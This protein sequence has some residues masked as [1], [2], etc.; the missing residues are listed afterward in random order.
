MLETPSGLRVLV[1]TVPSPV[2][3]IYLWI[4]AGSADERDNE[5][6][7][8]HFVEH[9]LFKGTAR[10]SVGE[11]ALEIE[12]HGGHVNAYTGHDHTVVHATVPASAWAETI[13]VLADM[14][15]E[16]LF[17]DDEFELER[18]VILDEIRGGD[19]DAARALADGVSAALFRVHPYGRPVIGK[20]AELRRLRSA[21]ARAFHARWYR[22]AN[23]L[24]SVAGPVSEEDVLE[25]AGRLFP[26]AVSAIDKPPRPVEPE[27]RRRR[28][29][30][31]FG[32]F[33]EP[34]I[35]LAFRGVPRDHPDAPVLDLLVGIL[36][37]SPGSLLGQRLQL[38]S[39]ATE[40]WC[41][42]EQEPDDGSFLVGFSPI[43]GQTE[44]CL[45]E[46]AR[47]LAEVAGGRHLGFG[48]LHRSRTQL[49]SGRVFVQETVDGRAHSRAWHTMRSGD[50]EGHT[51]AQAKLEA[52]TTRDLRRVAAERIRP[53]S[54]V[55]GG[56][57]PSGELDAAS[58]RQALA[59]PRIAPPKRPP[60]ILRETL[61]CGA[62][63]LI[64]PLEHSGVVALRVCGLGGL[65]AEGPTT[66]GLTS[67]WA[68][69]VG[70]EDLDVAE[71]AAFLDARGGAL[72]GVAGM[73]SFGLRT[74][75][76]AERFD[77]AARV[78]CGLLR[79]PTFPRD[80]VVRA[81]AELREAAALVVDEP[82]TLA[83]H[84]ACRLLF[85]GHPYALPEG[86][87]LEGL[88]RLGVASVRRMHRELVSGENL[89][90]AVVGTV[91]PAEVMRLLNKGLR[92]LASGPAA[93]PD[94]CAPV[95]PS[96]DEAEDI[97]SDREQAAIVLAWRGACF[98]T[99]D[100]AALNLAASILAGQ[101]GRLFLELRDRR[102]LAY[103][104]HADSVD[105]IDTGLFCAGMG[106][107]PRRVDEGVSG[108]RQVIGEL[109]EVGPTAE[110]LARSKRV[111]LGGMDMYRQRSESRAME[112]AYWERY[113]LDAV[114]ARE[115][116]A[117][118]IRALSAEDVRRALS[119]RLHAGVE[120]VVA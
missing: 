31:L 62:T 84:A 50:P 102:G 6:G 103:G 99:P 65:L 41:A 54:M 60:S 105:G 1:E 77:D 52:V 66:C 35:E 100:A 46:A 15:V 42:S 19:D 33:D 12:G 24:L 13:D 4:D 115:Q 47:V 21:D 79:A 51:R 29:V 32:R 69:S 118:E 83:W 64:E 71:L 9:M 48:N 2:A 86:G 16:P 91:E 107:D 5:R 25:T 36:A 56:L 43:R 81:R 97:E 59:F 27:Q 101:G 76:P 40:T 72:G 114:A 104:V 113:G 34:M 23:M 53:G 111:V 75:F 8:A 20:V 85:G 38:A 61:D 22:P 74:E 106:L 119:E 11:V 109:S 82:G 117:A 14:A 3:A 10:R 112:L 67:L 45:R 96:A 17:D 44:A 57:V 73:N 120:V 30:L 94:R 39:L 37:G 70:L 7:A 88:A 49:L 93:L 80:E 18:E 116:V 26:G 110:E 95:W 68:R 58:F 87:S 28:T 92:G 89:V 108:L 55:A 78:C 63:V 90:F 98:G